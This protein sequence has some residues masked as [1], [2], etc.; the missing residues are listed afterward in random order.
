MSRPLTSGAAALLAGLTLL[1]PARPPVPAWTLPA[2]DPPGGRVGYDVAAALPPGPPLS[3]EPDR[4]RDPA[5][6]PLRRGD[7]PATAGGAA[8]APFSASLDGAPILLAV[9]AFPVL[10]GGSV[11][12]TTKA[13][14]ILAYRDGRAEGDGGRWRWT[15]PDRPGPYPLRIVRDGAALE[16][17]AFVVHP[18]SRVRG[19]RLG[20]YPIGDY[21]EEPLRGDPSYLPPDGFVE[22]ARADQDLLV[23]PRLT[24]GQLLCKQP[25]EPRFLALSPSLV[26]KL[27]HLMDHLQGRG[28]DPASLVVM[29]GFR[30]P[31]YNRAIGNTTSYS[32]HLW[33]DAADV[34]VDADGDGEMDDLDGDGRVDLADARI[35]ARMVEE[36]AS[37]APVRP[38]GLAVYRR[39]AVH[40][41][42]VHVD[43][44]GS[45]ARW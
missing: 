15:A 24:V 5:L 22:V 25:G 28:L 41:P 33:G 8:T 44:R 40:G 27:E 9:T 23:S 13:G 18:R 39:N 38:G 34:Y 10:P 16:L 7:R 31:A 12:L 17:T 2:A 20:G 1:L 11:S 42:F 21:R 43:A 30:T 35:L 32:R 6:R 3:K 14:A 29:S 36:V 26:A 19:G 37:A 4:V 45:R